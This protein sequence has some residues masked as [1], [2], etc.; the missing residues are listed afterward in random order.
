MNEFISPHQNININISYNLAQSQEKV[1]KVIFGRKVPKIIKARCKDPDPELKNPRRTDFYF[2]KPDDKK[3][4][5]AK[6]P[7]PLRKKQNNFTT[8]TDEIVIPRRLKTEGNFNS[9]IVASTTCK[10]ES[11]T[12]T[13]NF[14]KS[15]WHNKSSTK[16]STGLIKSV[17]VKKPAVKSKK[18][19]PKNRNSS[20]MLYASK[21]HVMSDI[22]HVM[23]LVTE[24]KV[25]ARKRASSASV[26]RE[27]KFIGKLVNMS[28]LGSEM[29]GSIPMHENSAKSNPRFRSN[30]QDFMNSLDVRVL[31][32]MK[33]DQASTQNKSVLADLM[34]G[35]GLELITYLNKI[36]RIPMERLN[37]SA[38]V[39]QRFWREKAKESILPYYRDLFRNASLGMQ[40]MH[41]EDISGID[42]EVR[43]SSAYEE[44]PKTVFDEQE[45]AKN[46]CEGIDLLKK[47]KMSEDEEIADEN[48]S[49]FSDS[50][51][52]DPRE[53]EDPRAE[54][55][56]YNSSE[57]RLEE[58]E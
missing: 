35:E 9:E 55:E 58:A 51:E 52:E 21:K 25:Q 6:P 23:S 44:D 57:G 41:T 38:T 22:D 50:L 2:S 29:G 48:E 30:L 36:K 11:K 33:K 54:E 8:S 4:S 17:P 27:D 3:P 1:P 28:I 46:A 31:K 19:T 7:Q 56:E 14:S 39:I 18:E 42:I 12:S 40:T 10:K 45:V 16:Q 32:C 34:V 26:I 47:Y 37:Q 49:F 13:K 53:Q 20:C 15:V 24:P 43:S 5:A